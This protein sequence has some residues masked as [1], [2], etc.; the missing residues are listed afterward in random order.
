[1]T[2][3]RFIV[4][5]FCMVLFCPITAPPVAAQQEAPPHS[6][7]SLKEWNATEE[8]TFGAAI[9][10]VVAKN[11]IGA[12]FGLNLLMNGSQKVLYVNL[13]PNLSD[14]VKRSLTVGQVIQVVGIVRA[15]NGQNYL[16][17]RQ[18]LLG[19]QKIEVRNSRGFL[20]HTSSKAALRS[21]RPQSQFGGAR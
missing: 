18:L 12:P 8:I 5:A 19:D 7:P 16:L 6:F 4:A 11:P 17:A 21:P 9:A 10:E 20:T 14:D 3:H 2:T 15:F 1:V 13:G